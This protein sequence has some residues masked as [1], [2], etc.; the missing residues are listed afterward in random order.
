MQLETDYGA[1][2]WSFH[3]TALASGSSDSEAAA[4]RDMLEAFASSATELSSWTRPCSYR[5]VERVHV[6]DVARMTAREQQIAAEVAKM[7]EDL[8][9]APD[10]S[11]PTVP[12]ATRARGPSI[13]AP[14]VDLTPQI[15]ADAFQRL[16]L[17]DRRAFESYWSPPEA[18]IDDPDPAPESAPAVPAARST[19]PTEADAP[20]FAF[21]SRGSGDLQPSRVF[22]LLDYPSS[23][24]ETQELL[25]RGEASADDGAAS[26]R[27]PQDSP[28]PLLPLLD[29]LILVVD[30]SKE[31]SQRRKTVQPS[32]SERRKSITKQQSLPDV[33][34]LEAVRPQKS[35][36]QTANPMICAMY[37]ASSVGG[38]EWSDFVF[39]ELD[40]ASR[41]TKEPTPAVDLVRD[42]I[43]LVEPLATHKF[44]FKQ[45]VSSTVMAT[46]P[47]L[48]SSEDEG[49][50]RVCY[51][52]VLGRVCDA[53]IGVS[54]VLFA[55]K[56]AVAM[57]LEG[58]T[59][60]DASNQ[61]PQRYELEAFIDHGDVA[62]I[63]LARSCLHHH[64]L[65]E[66]LD[67][68]QEVNPCRIHGQRIDEIEKDMWA[69]SDLPGVGN[70][71]RKRMPKQPELTATTRSAL[72]TECSRFTDPI[73]ELECVHR[74]RQ[75]LQLEQTLGAPWHGRLRSRVFAEYLDIHIL[76]QRL[77]EILGNSPTVHTQYDPRTDSLLLATVAATAPGRLRTSSWSARDHIRHRPAFKEWRREEAVP[78]EYLTPRTALAV[79]ACVPLSSGELAQVSE[80]CWTLFPSD[81]SVVR[82]RQTPRDLRW[83]S[84][85]QQSDVFGLRPAA[86]ESAMQFVAS[87]QDGSLVQIAGGEQDSWLLK[88]DGFSAVTMT[89]TFPCG[90]SV[91][92]C[93]DGTIVQRYALSSKEDSEDNEDLELFRVI[94]GHGSVVRVLQSGKR[95]VLLASG[96][97]SPSQSRAS[98]LVVDPETNTLV[99]RHANGVLVAT[100]PSGARVTY[101]LDGTTMTM[102]ATRSHILVQHP[103]FADVWMDLE[104][105]TMASRHAMGQRVAVTKGGLRTR[106]IVTVYDG[107]R[108]ELGY[109]TKVIAQVNGRVTT[110]KPGGG[111]RVVA[112]DSGR[113]EYYPSSTTRVHSESSKDNDDLDVTSERGVYYFDLYKK[114]FELYDAEQNEFTVDL[115]PESEGEDDLR[116]TPRVT[117]ALAGVVSDSEASHN[118]VSPIAAHAVINDPIEPHVLLLEGDGTG[119]ELLRPCDIGPYLQALHSLK[120]GEGSKHQTFLDLVR[121]DAADK[122]DQTPPFGDPALVEEMRALQ[123]PVALVARHLPN[124]PRVPSSAP[125]FTVVRRLEQL[126]PL[127]P[128]QLQQLH[129]ALDQWTAWQEARE[130]NKNQ[131]TVL[132]PRDAETLAQEKALQARVLAASKATRARKKL[133]KRKAREQRH[134]SDKQPQQMA[135][136]TVHESDEHS[137]THGDGHSGES[138]SD[139]FDQFGSDDSDDGGDTDPAADVEDPSELIWT[140]FCEAD[141]AKSGLLTTAQ[142]K[143]SACPSSTVRCLT[144]FSK[145][146]ERSCTFSVP[147]SPAPSWLRRAEH[148]S[149][150]THL[151]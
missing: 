35:V 97:A 61:T 32:G 135:M 58:D 43:A 5:L 123:R 14:A 45:W 82:V 46:L 118:G 81:Q 8:V 119:I 143:P 19:T 85:Y 24:A 18:A 121:L 39:A 136:E 115:Q 36:F 7:A 90:L 111:P 73:A 126:E 3:S 99:E 139:E 23:L 132:D 125:Q 34:A 79:S 20:L 65:Q 28:L 104:V 83:L 80:K 122:G 137:Q 60:D 101:H 31:P 15:M 128:E 144:L 50:S 9:A 91:L 49:A 98:A 102:N 109:N 108:I 42:L 78:D 150:R 69:R 77:V 88:P 72:D 52:Q 110:T 70:S 103:R 105:N 6:E 133:E 68:S 56:E 74:T 53:S 33:D 141:S 59:D 55:L 76:P 16:V 2:R 87:L 142:G 48:E 30:P 131:Y 113:V 86:S 71:G 37:E 89:N 93:S 64:H 100:R 29:G 129:Q 27:A 66:K 140:A 38:L 148:C 67:Q 107:T 44:A 117:V 40:C 147:V 112:K 21:E 151:R 130:I 11:E 1:Q 75:L 10:L 57:A 96:A 17:E 47:A 4:L 41:V 114:R 51:N 62:S 12:A 116:P 124:Y 54:T 22:L 149:S 25:R 26:T 92:A 127:A 138:E 146:G 134:K 145:L 94:T 84:V 106:S 13:V 95:Q 120:A 63:R